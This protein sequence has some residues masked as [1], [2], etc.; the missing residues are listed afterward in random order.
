MDDYEVERPTFCAVRDIVANQLTIRDIDGNYHVLQRKE[1]ASWLID[2]QLGK[3]AFQL[4]V[5]P[6]HSFYVTQN[7]FFK[8]NDWL[9]LNNA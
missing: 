3:H 1:G 5:D 6:H 7:T 8:V 4:F 9:A 2:R